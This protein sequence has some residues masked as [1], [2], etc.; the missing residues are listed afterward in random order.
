MTSGDRAPGEPPRLQSWVETWMRA[1][2][3]LGRATPARR[4]TVLAD[5]QAGSQ[6]TLDVLRRC[7]ASR[8]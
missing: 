5:I 2:R 3:E 8:S 1:L 4:A 7:S 6:P